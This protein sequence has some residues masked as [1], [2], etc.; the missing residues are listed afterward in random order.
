MKSRVNTFAYRAAYTL[1]FLLTLHC[2]N[3]SALAQFGVIDTIAATGDQ[4]PDP[5]GPGGF[6][7]FLGSF[8]P[9]TLNNG[10]QVAFNAFNITGTSASTADDQAIYL[11]TTSTLTQV[12]REGQLVPLGN[13]NF[14]S[15]FSTPL[16]N[17][18]GQVV[19]TDT[20]I[21]NT[22][23]GSLDNDGVYHFNAGTLSQLERTNTA[24]VTLFNMPSFTD[25]GVA[26]NF[27]RSGSNTS[28]DGKL[29]GKFISG[30]ST[31][32]LEGFTVPDANG[33]YADPISFGPITPAANTTGQTAFGLRI[34]GTSGGFA[35]DSA[36]FRIQVTN[37]VIIAREGDNAPFGGGQIGDQTFNTP[38]ISP[39]GQVAFR[40]SLTATTGGSTDDAAIYRGSGGNLTQIA[41]EGQTAPGGN[42]TFSFLNNPTDIN[43][44]NQVVFRSSLTSTIEGSLDDT[45][46]YRGSGGTPT[47]I[48]R[49][50]DT[51]PDANGKFSSLSS[52]NYLNDTGQVVFTSSLRD[53]AGST[54][55]D[56]GV[57]LGDGQEIIR[58]AREGQT[59]AG[60]TITSLSIINGT[61]TGSKSPIND[62]AQVAFQATLANGDQGVFL[63][64]PQLH[65]RNKFS[66]NWD[67]ASN[68][69][70]GLAPGSLYDVF[71]DPAGSL[72]VNGPTSDT[73]VKSLQ[74]GGATGIATL[75]LQTGAVITP[76]TGVVTITPTGVLTG[77]GTINAAVQNSGTI[78]A[79]N[80]TITGNITNTGIVNGSGR[81]NAALTNAV[82][83]EVRA[84]A[85][86]LLHF[87]STSGHTN[88][89]L[90]DVNGQDGLAT[91]EFDATLNNAS[92]TG[93]IQAR[94]SAR[95]RF[96]AGLTNN[97]SLGLA[98][99]DAT[100][101]GP[102]TNNGFIA[103]SGNS[104]VLFS[105][106]V[107]NN[108]AFDASGGS[109][110]VFFGSYSGNGITGGPGAN[111]TMQGDL[112]PGASPGI[113]SFG[114]NVN[115]GPLATVEIEIT[116]SDNT[117]PNNP[118]FDQVTVTNNVS[119][120]GSLKLLV[121]T[122][123]FT[124][125]YGN[126]FTILTYGSRTGT[127]D[128]T[129]LNG[130]ILA[131]QTDL[132]LAPVYDFPGSAD[133]LFAAT[134]FA[135]APNSLTLFTTL[136]G[137]ANL[138]LQVEDADLSLLLT[139]FGNTNAAWTQGDFTGDGLVDDA[140]LSLLLTNFGGDVRSLFSSTGLSTN[141]AVI[142]EPATITLLSLTCLFITSLRSRRGLA[143]ATTLR[144]RR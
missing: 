119:L 109:N 107:T 3:P 130:S 85:D 93:F 99:A 81:I 111:V 11:A 4:A 18:S 29:R 23:A 131:L 27:L 40:T 66:N 50:G 45:G 39:S 56:F 133:P 68:W 19:F 87:T 70:I 33:T 95:L 25:A 12:V 24:G 44:L 42:G 138:D 47:Q 76:A 77:D 2:T 121:D 13:G 6:N 57:F 83:G 120:D 69:T 21:Q 143:R 125:V 64:T 101:F 35:D 73:A 123:I 92:S 26:W 30:S 141:A 97:G 48:A 79:D 20:F 43:V 88:Q 65:W 74:I 90:I 7:G 114:G 1:A 100:V 124:P 62:A 106:D 102:I 140:D 132:A 61:N 98:F 72:T 117:D 17:S 10:G 54:T 129:T 89:G 53:T 60:N 144:S 84:E 105:G 108:A 75:D 96:N 36:V 63:F 31:S 127:F 113:S 52:S 16:I 5:A 59:L 82:S 137:D 32:S 78:T 71:I 104:N 8:N 142:P 136:P 15:F 55:D 46:I 128:T 41:R 9:P 103:V 126:T 80:L 134:P 28:N 14:S 38:V 112:R 110:L 135:A 49:E 122:N 91:I 51:A 94:G 58:V 139:S 37:R 34:L 118:Q 86:D 67:F 22:S 115:F 116:G